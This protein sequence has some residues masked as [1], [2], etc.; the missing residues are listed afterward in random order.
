VLQLGV[1]PG[2]A[3]GISG[4]EPPGAIGCVGSPPGDIGG[5]THAPSGGMWI[6]GVGWPSTIIGGIT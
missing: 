3:G 4:R 1:A 2:V 5:I 6:G